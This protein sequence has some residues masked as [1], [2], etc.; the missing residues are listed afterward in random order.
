MLDAIWRAKQLCELPQ[1]R[2]GPGIVTRLRRNR[3]PSQEK[4]W[5]DPRGHPDYP[6][7]VGQIYFA[8]NDRALDADDREAIGAAIDYYRSY[9]GNF[10]RNSRVLFKFV[11]NADSRGD[12]KYNLWLGKVRAEA[13]KN[14]FDSK[15]SDYQY[16]HSVAESLGET[17][18]SGNLKGSRRVDVFSSFIISRDTSVHFE[19]QLL[20]G[21]YHSLKGRK[22]KIRTISGGGLGFLVFGGTVL[23]IEIMSPR[24]ERSAF[25]TLTSLTGGVSFGL[26]RPTGWTDF[27]AK[28]YLEVDDFEGNGRILFSASAV[29]AGGQIL[30]F[31]GPVERGLCTKPVTIAL[32]G[33]DL[34]AGVSM[35]FAGYW[36]RVGE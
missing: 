6:G 1:G 28:E 8:T 30:E 17:K 12:A 33:W 2:M 9:Y 25:Y 20:L 19:N 22:F 32:D 4:S 31:W 27:D 3:Q 7:L 21:K 11:G 16:Y 5:M 18:A 26:A 10:Y 36:H 23:T 13:V 14:F 15:F 29:V 24:S 35:D 34:Q